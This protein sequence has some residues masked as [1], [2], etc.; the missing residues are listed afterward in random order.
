MRTNMNWRL[1]VNMRLI[2]NM[3]LTVNM[4]LSGDGRLCTLLKL[5]QLQVGACP[6]GHGLH[7]LASSYAD[8]SAMS[9]LRG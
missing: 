3:R 7:Y 1:S 5:N 6:R 2:I 9:N 8:S 4:R